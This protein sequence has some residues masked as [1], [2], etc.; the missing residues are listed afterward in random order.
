MK[1]YF[2]RHATA[3]RKSTWRQDDALRPLTRTGRQRFTVA[4][5]SLVQ[6]GALHPDLIITSPLVRAEQTAQLLGKALG[7]SVPVVEDARLGHEFDVLALRA[8]LAEH[9]HARSIAIV[10]HNPSFA[11]V[12]CEVVG[13]AELDVRKGAVALVELAAVAPPRGRL[14]WLAPPTI[15]PGCP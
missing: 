12:L 6:A 4:V 5:S 14:M 7:R 10:G 1:L 13:D 9:R 8:I 3:A 15:F 11:N 2:V